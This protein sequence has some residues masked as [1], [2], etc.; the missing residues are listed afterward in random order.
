M[1]FAAGGEGSILPEKLFDLFI[2]VDQES[3]ALVGLWSDKG[4]RMAGLIYECVVLG[5]G[6]RIAID[7]KTAGLRPSARL[8]LVPTIGSGNF[9][10]QPISMFSFFSRATHP[11]FPLRDIK[12]SGVMGALLNLR[13]FL[14]IPRSGS[15]QKKGSE[16]ED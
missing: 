7:A 14:T 13:K 8:L 1:I 6:H 15:R 3:L 2:R 4:L 11:K 5:I 12:L 16:S 10:V 9:L